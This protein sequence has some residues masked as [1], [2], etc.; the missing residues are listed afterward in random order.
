MKGDRSSIEEARRSEDKEKQMAVHELMVLF[1]SQLREQTVVW[2]ERV[3]LV[4]VINGEPAHLRPVFC[5]RYEHFET[6]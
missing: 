4:I 6:A 5:R 2:S 1:A 3:D